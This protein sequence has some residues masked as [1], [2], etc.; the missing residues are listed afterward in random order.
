[1]DQYYTVRTPQLSVIPRRYEGSI[2]KIIERSTSYHRSFIEFGDG[3][4]W[5]CRNTDLIPIDR[6]K[7]IVKVKYADEDRYAKVI[8]TYKYKVVVQIKRGELIGYKREHI[9]SIVSNN[10]FDYIRW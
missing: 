1:M 8:R 2:C 6:N 7:K 5:S 3:L 4:R 9:L 10:K